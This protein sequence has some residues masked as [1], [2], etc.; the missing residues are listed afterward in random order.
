[1][2]RMVVDPPTFHSNLRDYYHVHENARMEPYHSPES[3]KNFSITL[4]SVL[5]KIILKASFDA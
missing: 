3:R 2:D 1:M 4:P 5:M